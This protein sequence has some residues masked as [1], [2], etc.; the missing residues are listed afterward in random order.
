MKNQVKYFLIPVLAS[1]LLFLFSTVG[2]AQ[3]QTARPNTSTTS[4]SNGYYEYLPQGYY[5]GSQSYPLLIFVH[6]LGEMGDGS[7]SQLPRVIGG[8]LPNAIENGKF[9]V[10]V[11]A[12][13]GSG[14]LFKFIVISPQFAQWPGGPDISNVIDYAVSHYRV[15]INRIYL[16]GLSMGGGVVFDYAGY[17]PSYSNRVAA[18]VPIAAA[19][20]PWAP[21]MQNIAE[22][23]LP[24]WATHNDSDNVVPVSN[25][26]NSVDYINTSPVPPNP[27]AR[28]T[29]FHSYGHDAWTKTYD[30][31]YKEN[32]MNIYEWML[33]YKRS[34]TT[35]PVTGLELNAVR[36]DD[37][38]I[39]LQWKTITERNSR[40]FEIQRSRDGVTFAALGF[41][42]SQSVNG[43]GSNYSY[44]DGLPL[45]GKNYYRLKQFDVD[46]S[47]SFSTIRFVEMNRKQSITVYPNPVSDVLNINTTGYDFAHAQ[48]RIVDINGRVLRQQTISSNQV[49]INLRGLMS[50]VY[51]GEIT[52]NKVTARFRFVKQ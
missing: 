50:G 3:V 47:V 1:L 17:W 2:M 30:T 25:T 11:H 18:I 19:N 41:V 24:V 4:I 26:I 14:S 6:G 28:K 51:A 35:L 20:W 39:L 42:N 43:G 44:T 36:K 13:G 27:L 8:G 37:K 29:I 16:T 23:N 9:P 5:A 40:G 7:P 49:S 21:S 32:N 12:G 15:D 33:Q 10:S 52:E 34:F 31:L 22:A 38:N 45:D 48:L 46:G